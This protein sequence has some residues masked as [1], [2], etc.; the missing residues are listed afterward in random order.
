LTGTAGTSQNIS[1]TLS[2]SSGAVFGET[3]YEILPPAGFTASYDTSATAIG[4][5]CQTCATP[6]LTL[7]ATDAVIINPGG[8][9]TLRG[10]S[11]DRLITLDPHVDTATH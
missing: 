5:A 4:T 6:S 10:A 11:P 9:D 7:T 2:A 3:F 1:V 8:A